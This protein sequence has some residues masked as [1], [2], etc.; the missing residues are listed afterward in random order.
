MIVLELRLKNINIA[1]TFSFFALFAVLFYSNEN[2]KI[3][4]ALFSCL[5]HELGHIA[6]MC[7]FKCPP[8]SITFYGG[9]IKL[10]PN[11]RLVS[12]KQEIAVLSAGCIT[13]LILGLLLIYTNTFTTFAV[14]NLTLGLFNLLPFRAFDG[15]Q[16]LK[17][18]SCNL[19]DKGLLKFYNLFVNFLC[20]IIVFLGLIFMI[21]YRMSI[22]LAVTI[23][24]I[25]VSQVMS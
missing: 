3:L 2:T 7:L 10:T 15:G 12:Y 20:I 13:N 6:L 16:I 11:C 19:Q 21:K 9:G 1:V 23:C 17:I 4:L 25:I 8:K 18:L 14:A 5:F 22:S 24:Y